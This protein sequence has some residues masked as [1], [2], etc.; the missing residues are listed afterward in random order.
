LADGSI[1][2]EVNK[3]AFEQGNNEV[4]SARSGTGIGEKLVGEAMR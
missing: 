2:Y 1:G 3:K 4:V